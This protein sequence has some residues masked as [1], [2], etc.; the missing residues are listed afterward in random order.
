MVTSLPLISCRDGVSASCVLNKHHWDGFDKRASWNTSTPLQFVYSNLC[1]MLPFP[2]FSECMY[3]LTF[4][5]DFSKHTW[6]YFL[7]L[8]SEVFGMFLD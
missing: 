8:K 2:S 4:I 5:G 1:D 7:K 3:F 6:V